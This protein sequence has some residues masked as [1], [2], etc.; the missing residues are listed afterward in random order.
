VADT[1]L[2]N[3]SDTAHWVA[4]YRAIE[5]ERRDAHFHD[6]YARR[7]AGERG[8]AM[9]RHMGGPSGGW[10]MVVRT[11]AIDALL[12]RLIR[13]QHADTVVSLAAGLDARPWRMELP[14]ALRWIEVDLPP[15]VEYKRQALAGET[16]R[17]A[18]ESIPADLADVD[19]RRAL[20]QRF[21][22]LTNRGVLLTEGLLVYLDPE[23]VATL[24][25][26]VADCGAF[27][28]WIMDL[29]TPRI[30]AMLQKRWGS[31]LAQ[32]N[33][34]LKF[35]PAEGTGFFRP[36]GW[37]ESEFI[38]T[39]E[40]GKRLHRMP[41]GAWMWRLMEMFMPESR[42]EEGRRMAGIALLERHTA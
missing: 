34:P 6:P 42:R 30:L 40:E 14:P 11:V 13:E 37:K 17:V 41:P 21:A 38:S 1:P 33:A 9:L 5:S 23:Q 35:G 24:A 18:L 10:P 7:L 3:V 12:T 16:P 29:A 39:W 36:H 8:E 15:M 19:A 2:R 25:R 4:L 28:W 20:F 26:E 32:G 27:R 22:G 31:K